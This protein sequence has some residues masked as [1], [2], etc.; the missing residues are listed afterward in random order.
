M[1]KRF[2]PVF[3]NQ[4]K[5]RVAAK[6]STPKP[7]LKVSVAPITKIDEEADLTTEEDL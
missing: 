1:A 5:S 3:N 4:L 2:S 7:F 6:V